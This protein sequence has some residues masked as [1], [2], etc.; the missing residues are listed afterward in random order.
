MTSPLE[1]RH[2]PEREAQ[3]LLERARRKLQ[4]CERNRDEYR[5][6]YR[7]AHRERASRQEL[8]QIEEKGREA[9]ARIGIGQQYIQTLERD[10]KR[11]IQ[12]E[13]SRDRQRD[14]LGPLKDGAEV[15]EVRRLRREGLSIGDA[16]QRVIGARQQDGRG[17]GDVSRERTVRQ[18]EGRDRPLSAT[19]KEA[20]ERLGVS[21]TTVRRRVERGELEGRKGEDGRLKISLASPGQ[22][23]SHAR[24]QGRS[25][26]PGRRSKAKIRGREAEKDHDLEIDR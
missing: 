5:E 23:R 13:K 2:D 3:D 11:H 10:I 18:E 1:Q 19:V 14:G 12:Q 17:V 24:E 21:E 25:A 26:G 22:E 15:D 4:M 20:A 7:H 6:L 8:E 9:A 16:R